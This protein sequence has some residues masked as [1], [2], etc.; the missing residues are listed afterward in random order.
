MERSYVVLTADHGELNER[1]ERGHF[2]SLIFD[3]LIHV[4][5][6]V[7]QPGQNQ[8]KDVYTSTSSVDVLPTLAHLLGKP[9]PDWVEGELLPGFGG[10]E[11]LERSIYS[12]DAK[13]NASFAPLTQTS[14]SLTK[15]QHRLTY[16]AYQDDQQFEFYNLEEDREELHDLYPSLPA[17]ARR[18][19]AELLQKLDEIN[20][21]TEL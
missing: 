7:F 11:N 1:G 4:P 5:L 20:R 19:K 6:I 17:L 16:Y 3:P 21:S 9:V 13:T 10:D 12:M 18:M 14:I 15:N 2:T 8:R